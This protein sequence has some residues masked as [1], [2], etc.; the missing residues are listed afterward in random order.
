MDRQEM[1]AS[2]RVLA[3]RSFAT[4]FLAVMAVVG[5]LV[6]WR[7]RKALPVLCA[8]D[9]IQSVRDAL[10]VELSER[11]PLKCFCID[12]NGAY[13]RL[14]GR[15]LCNERMRYA[16]GMLGY[17]FDAPRSDVPTPVPDRIREESAWCKATGIPFLWVLAPCKIDWNGDLLPPGWTV[18]NPNREAS[19]IA[20]QLAAEGIETL[21]L[22]HAFAGT[23]ELVTCNFFE[24][25]HHWRY[26]AALRATGML[27]DR[28]A[29]LIPD[30]SLK[31]QSN[32]QDENWNWTDT[33][34]TFLGSHGRRVGRCFG[35]LSR[36]RYCE[37]RYRSSITR[38]NVSSGRTYKGDFA[39]AEMVGHLLKEDDPYG[40]NRYGLYT[41]SD[42]GLQLH[43]NSRAPNRRRIMIIKDSFGDP[44]SAFLATV[45]T[46][47]IQVDPRRLVAG[48]SVLELLESHH[49]DAVV[50]CCNARTVFAPKADGR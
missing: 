31:G 21:D 20:G 34:C 18:R 38:R 33:G 30:P 27:V 24:T 37:P 16:N 14:L 7:L 49:P 42:V 36:F 12:L 8:H 10:S 48:Q 2:A 46:E 1:L 47:V 6:V 17:A 3:A 43:K 11:F 13:C 39:K 19:A 25:D 5:S 41:G 9:S 23:P 22:I 26:E 50:E 15:R 40:R 29:D 28:L 45:F 32:L 44:V 35:G 4:L